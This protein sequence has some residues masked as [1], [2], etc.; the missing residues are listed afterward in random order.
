[1]TTKTNTTQSSY[2][3]SAIEEPSTGGRNSTGMSS[4]NS[5]IFVIKP[6]SANKSPAH[7][8]QN[9]G[10]TILGGIR[11]KSSFNFFFF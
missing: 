8:R 1:M 5:R 10:R 7:P 4:A 3:N 6:D 11:C 9:I 2:A